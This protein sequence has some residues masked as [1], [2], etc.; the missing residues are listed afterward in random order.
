[1][2]NDALSS[3]TECAD[4]YVG[5][6]RSRTR[7]LIEDH[8]AVD[9]SFRL[10][11]PLH[12]DPNLSRD[13]HDWFNIIA[14][15]PVVAANVVNWRDPRHLA[16]GSSIADLW[17]GDSFDLLWNVAFAYFTVDLAWMFLIPNCVR[18]PSVIVKHHIVTMSYLVVPRLYPCYGWLMGAN[19]LVEVNTW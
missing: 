16:R 4:M 8:F 7:S 2:L 13:V 5:A 18:S 3:A 11:G 10:L 17:H 1:M 9:G 19:M 15:I 6:A 14:L 12:H